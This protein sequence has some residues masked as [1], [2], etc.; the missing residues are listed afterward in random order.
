MSVSKDV[1]SNAMGVSEDVISCSRC[2]YLNTN[3]DQLPC[4]NFWELPIDNMEAFCSFYM[5][6]L[7]NYWY[8]DDEDDEED[9]EEDKDE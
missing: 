2:A 7:K 8:E 4:C 9:E 6:E 1:I 3:I 5:P